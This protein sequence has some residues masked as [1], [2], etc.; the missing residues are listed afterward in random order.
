MG[1]GCEVTIAIPTYGRDQV[2]L[3]TVAHLLRQEPRAAEILLVD[4]TPQHNDATESALQA[5]ADQ[6]QVRW[7][8]LERPSITGAMNRALL[9]ASSPIVLFVD[10]D[11]V[12]ASGLVAA[13]AAAHARFPAAW[14]IA[15]QVLQPG[16][17]P[18]ADAPACTQAGLH[19]HLDFPFC[20]TTA[21]KV[22]SVM[23]GNLSV[24]RDR[25][26]EI[27]GFDENFVGV[28]YRFETEFARRIWHR[29][30]EVVYDPAAS[31][32]HL[33]VSRGGTRRFGSHLSSPSPAHGVGDYY[34]A[35]RQGLSMQTVCYV[36][37]RPIR[38]VCTRFHLRHPWYIPLKLFGELAALAW[39]IGLKVRGPRRIASPGPSEGA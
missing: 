10:D 26:I 3:D 16:Q 19:A 17:E 35:L 8:R 12:P 32:R 38:E 11:I 23:A 30:G 36:A 18:T 39:A 22:R 27:G 15:G 20:S 13:H 37:R 21:A 7:L 31:I 1:E 24:K 28:A 5:W 2:L 34:F 25:A 6:G 33:R 14:A 29:G 4:Q 9:E